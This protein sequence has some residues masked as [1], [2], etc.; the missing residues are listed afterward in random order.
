MKGGSAEERDEKQNFQFW[1]PDGQMD[2]GAKRKEWAQRE[3]K[4]FWHIKFDLSMG[5]LNQHV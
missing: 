5:H 2:D 4:F 3:T 1:N